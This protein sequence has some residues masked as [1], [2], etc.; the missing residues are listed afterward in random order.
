[1]AQNEVFVY[2]PELLAKGTLVVIHN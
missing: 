2:R 1:M